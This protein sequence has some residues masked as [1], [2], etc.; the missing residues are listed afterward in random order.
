MSGPP[1]PHPNLSSI[2]LKK[3][4]AHHAIPSLISK[5]SHHL[6]QVPTSPRSNVPLQP[7]L[8][9]LLPPSI[10]GRGTP[11]SSFTLPSLSRYPFLYVVNPPAL[12]LRLYKDTSFMTRV[13]MYPS[14][15]GTVPVYTCCP[16]TVSNNVRFTFTRVCP[17]SKCHPIYETSMPPPGLKDL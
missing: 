8:L 4:K 14:L 11:M 17:E 1:H 10:S 5:T 16:L 13:T 7:H 15:H 3:K 2:D 12:A 6:R 9:L